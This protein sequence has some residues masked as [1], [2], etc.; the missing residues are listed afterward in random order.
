[1]DV[2]STNLQKLRD[3]IMSIWIKISEECFQ[4]L[5]ESMPRRI[6]AVRKEKVGPTR[7]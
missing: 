2:L 1:M 6:K 4:N 7:Y 3:A 5:F